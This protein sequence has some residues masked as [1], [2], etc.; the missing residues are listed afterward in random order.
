MIRHIL[1]VYLRSLDCF[2][3]PEASIEVCRNQQTTDLIK[4]N[5][6]AKDQ[7]MKFIPYM[8][9]YCR[10]RID[11]V[12]CDLRGW[13]AAKRDSCANDTVMGLRTELECSL[14]PDYCLE[15]YTREVS[16][17]CSVDKF[18][19]EQRDP[20]N[21]PESG[22]SHDHDDKNSATSVRFSLYFVL[23]FFSTR[24]L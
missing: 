11:H 15:N 13:A 2:T 3:H 5:I 7:A 19:R 4:L 9:E 20:N 14:L 6:K 17:M 10:I 18:K 23:I 8:E 21:I 1:K 16:V 12:S 24:A 22:H